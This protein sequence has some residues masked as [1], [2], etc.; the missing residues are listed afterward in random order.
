MSDLR[1]LTS[2]EL[3]EAV[4]AA[5]LAFNSD[6][7]PEDL[8]LDVRV[9]GRARTLGAFED[10][11]PIATGGWL[12]L[13]MSVPG[14]A[15]PVAGVTFVSVSPV[16]RRRGLLRQLMTR[17]LAD[18]HAE[19]R[20]LAALWASEGAIYQRFGYGLASWQLSVEVRRGAAFHR[21]VTT[22]GL[23]LVTPSARVLAPVF[24]AAVASRPGWYSRD[25]KWWT[26]RLHDPAHQRNGSSPLRCLLDGTEGYALFSTTDEWEQT[27]A[28]HTVQV[29]EL[30]A[31]TPKSEARLWRL[32]LDLDL[33]RTTKAGQLPVDT[34][35]L[36][37]LAEP[38][39][40]AGRLGDGLYVRLVSLDG[41]AGRRYAVAVDVVLDV[42]DELCPWNAGRWRLSGDRDGAVCAPTTD[43]ADLTLHVR[44]LGAA[45]LGGT[46]L[47]ARAAAGCVTEHTRGALDAA[48]TGFGWPGRAAH[49]P[50]VF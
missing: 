14:A 8:E 34:P 5:G 36:H 47:A 6:L 1:P 2:A 50:M 27:G 29:R 30:V 44:D 24:D 40:A 49:C 46:S 42:Q 15:A 31:C 37:L 45:F 10:G 35:L 28:A 3:P 9:L 4:A 23:Q 41:L 12:D 26:Y 16:H 38:R 48:T 21:P 11:T 17:Q 13:E 22:E 43:R 39:S 33:T 18:L 19:G 32:L 7:H 25:E 20:S